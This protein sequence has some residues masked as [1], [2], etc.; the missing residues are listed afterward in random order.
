[1]KTPASH[2]RDN[3]DSD[4]IVTPESDMNI[5]GTTYLPTIDSKGFLEFTV[6]LPRDI[7]RQG[8]ETIVIY[9]II[10]MIL[11]LVIIGVSL[12]IIDRLVLIRLRTLIV[13]IKKR[14]TERTTMQG[15]LLNGNDEF[16]RL[17]QEIHPIFSELN[18]SRMELEEH[19]RLL[20]ESERKYRELADLL[21]EFVFESDWMAIS[22]SSIR[23]VR[24]FPGI[25]PK[26]RPVAFI[27]LP[28]SILITML[29]S[30]LP[31]KRSDRGDQLPDM[32]LPG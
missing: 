11:G 25:A 21:P 15:P 24:I 31:W 22:R 30:V 26:K 3:T 6:R 27:F 9:I 8:T 29:N 2:I 4:I 32:S 17:A 23:W 16:S 12:L 19:N 7:I 28:F 13:N 18:R 10:L 20:V 1:L 5:T 14:N